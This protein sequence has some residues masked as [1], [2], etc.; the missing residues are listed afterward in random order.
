MTLTQELAQQMA[1]NVKRIVEE[2]NRECSV[3]GAA[4]LKVEMRFDKVNL[5]G[6]R[7]EYPIIS[8][9]VSLPL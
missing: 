7:G 4:G 2:L 5:I 6:H 3:V 8:A 1:A 9:T